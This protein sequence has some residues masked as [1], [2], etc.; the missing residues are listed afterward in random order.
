MAR[1]RTD[2]VPLAAS[3]MA[4]PRLQKETLDTIAEPDLTGSRSLALYHKGNCR[5]S[6]V[7]P[8][9][10]KCRSPATLSA[11]VSDQAIDV[12]L[13]PA[14]KLSPVTRSRHKLA[15]LVGSG[16]PVSRMRSSFARDGGTQLSAPRSFAYRA[17]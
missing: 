13:E 9:Q 11:R 6:V 5:G 4:R 10:G 3:E 12:E 14:L 17:R 15:F 1:D 16:N 8:S 2:K 7:R